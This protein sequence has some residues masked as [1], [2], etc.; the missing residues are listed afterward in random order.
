MLKRGVECNTITYNTL[1]DACGKCDAMCRAS[2]LLEDMSKA[3]VEPDIITYSTL[4]KGYCIEG[5]VEKAFRVL[6][7][8]KAQG[9]LQPDEIMYNSLLDGCAKQQRVED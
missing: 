6:E 2:G 9:K 7:D 4:I 5:S 3:N 8:M 1:L